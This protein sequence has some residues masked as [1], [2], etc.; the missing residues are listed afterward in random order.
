MS[1]MIS[2]L[3]WDVYLYLVTDVSGQPIDTIFK[4]PG[5]EEDRL[6]LEDGTDRSSRNVGDYLPINAA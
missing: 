6:T 4:G 2:S 1:L 3:L 5:A